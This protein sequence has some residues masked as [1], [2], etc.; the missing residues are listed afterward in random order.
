MNVRE[1]S[2]VLTGATGHFGR[3]LARRLVARG[4]RVLLVARTAPALA[5]LALEL[6]A[7]DEQR[8]R[9]DA[10]AADV[11]RAADRCAIRDA[12]I[13]R[14][15]NALV[16]AACAD[17]T[18]ALDLIDP[19]QVETIV[20]TNLLAPVQMTRAL[21]P[22]L[23][24]QPQARVLNIGSMLGRVGRPGHA[25]FSASKFGLRGFSEALRRELAGTPVRV[26]L[27]ALRRIPDTADGRQLAGDRAAT[28]APGQPDYAALAAVRMLCSGAAERQ[29]GLP[30]AALGRVNGLAPR[31]L[32]ALLARGNPARR[33]RERAAT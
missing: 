2:V 21:L 13:A 10:L 18:G 12:A 9:V 7:A 20:L 17:Q 26:Q 22:H 25:A 14:G 24:A 1:L 11:T 4:A 27:L 16:N 23:L 29:L 32:D 30:D 6:G 31:W 5:A 8:Q 19:A 3:A 15:A 33:A 28:Q